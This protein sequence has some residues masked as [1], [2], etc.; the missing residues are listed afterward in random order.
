MKDSLCRGTQINNAVA[1]GRKCID[2]DVCSNFHNYLEMT[3]NGRL[4]RINNFMLK[5]PRVKLG[6][7]K[8]GFCL[9]GVK[10]YNFMAIEIRRAHIL[11]L[12]TC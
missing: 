11:A 1:L 5:I 7:T 4:T 2:G 12:R 10:L 9:I 3:S 8:Q 6:F